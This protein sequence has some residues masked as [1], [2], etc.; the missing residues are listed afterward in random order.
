MTESVEPPMGQEPVTSVL[1]TEVEGK[2]KRRMLIPALAVGALAVV[3]GGATWAA[4][5]LMSSGAPVTSALPASTLGYVSIDLDP[6]ASQKIE[7]VKIMKKFP[8]LTEDLDFDLGAQDD[9]RAWVFEQIAAESDCDSIDYAKQVEPWLSNRAAVAAAEGPDGEPA[10]LIVLQVSDEAKARDAL[11]NGFGCEGAV[12]EDGLAFVGEYAVLAET[13]KEA[14]FFAKAATES[15]LAEDPDH[16]AWMERVGEAGIITA[17]AAPDALAAVADS[18]DDM[19]AMSSDESDILANFVEGFGGAAATVRFDDGAIEFE[20]V[21]QTP[22]G[23]L[24][25]AQEGKAPLAGLPDT[26]AFAVGAALSEGWADTVFDQMSE[27]GGE[28]FDSDLADFEQGVGLSFPEDLE[29]LLGSGF[30][31][32]VDSSFDP[33][34]AAD[35]QGLPVLTELPVGLRLGSDAADVERILGGVQPMLA[36]FGL[37]LFTEAGDGVVGVSPSPTYASALAA[38]GSLGETDAYRAAIPN[39]DEAASALFFNVPAAE[40]WILDAAHGDA[41]DDA[42]RNSAPLLSIGASSW[43]DGEYVRASLRIA[44]K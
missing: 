41:D 32:A 14:D 13:Q 24:P 7:A 9:I 21:S 38:D 43:L 26:T 23:S 28:A 8:A 34:L 37:E 25:A 22:E 17:Y 1:S 18:A 39:A 29:A 20:A 36:F 30:A 10:P 19:G 2:G 44:T 11:A 6:S 3:G 35:A 33:S 15:P 27:A 12:Y 16:K 42:V 40:A 31:L 4:L 5:Q